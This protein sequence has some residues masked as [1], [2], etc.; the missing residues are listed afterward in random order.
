MS[1]DTIPDRLLAQAAAR[2]DAPA[3]WHQPADSGWQAISWRQYA[4]LAEAFAGALLAMDY[5]PGW[6]VAI[7]SDNC[8][9]WLV[10]DLGA[11]LARAVPA[12]VYPT[13]TAEQAAY[14]ISHCEA[15]VVV[16]QDP[17]QWA[18]LQ[19]VLDQ[20]PALKRVVIIHGADAVDD[21]LAVG[22]EA[23]LD[24]GRAHGEAVQ[25][26]VA[27]LVPEDLGTLIYTS[28]TTGHPK[29]VMLDHRNLAFTA[30]SALSAVGEV[31]PE[32]CM[33]SYLPLSHIAEQ[34]FS[35][36]LHTTAGYPLWLCPRLE[37]LKATLLV[38]RPTFFL[39][40][41]RVWEKFKAA[42][43]GK[44]GELTGVKGAIA[45][46]ALAVGLRA[47]PDLVAHGEASGALGWQ[48]RLADRLFYGKLKAQLGLDRLK[49]ASSG[50]APIGRDVVQ[51][52]WAIGVPIHEVYGQSEGTGP[53]T[54]NRP[55]PGERRLGTVGLPLPGVEV[56]IAEDGEILVRGD[57][58]FVGY[59]K[60][61]AD[62]AEALQDGW[63]HSGDVGRF[64]ADGF[65]C[66]TDRKKDL[67]ITAGGKNVAPQHIEALLKGIAGVGQAVVIGDRRKYLSA[68]LTVDPEAT[69]ALAAQHGWPT[70]PQALAAH[71]G[72]KA[73]VDAGVAAVNGQLARYETLKRW[74]VL[75]DDFTLEG[76]ELTPTQKV[77]RRV[78]DAKYA[79]QIEALYA[80]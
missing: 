50:A 35:V 72:F 20:L 18:K 80:P 54:F 59:L 19:S 38:A 67:I 77:K 29:G 64:D 63:L 14:I 75:P 51:F 52:F 62:T 57:N 73:H 49:V 1:R 26:R 4:E 66:I 17:L 65:L 32:D 46:W 39:G 55:V 5:A 16:V 21:P 78:V 79:A 69:P 28:G 12:G 40:V 13:L 24:E 30:R 22:F 42:L 61:P 2:P 10:A 36:H 56:R 58:V 27:E 60:Q 47:V 15:R 48:H 44:L 9:P 25:A 43:E 11:M 76:G 71:A 33:I 70:D 3:L 74:T 68:L 41:P 45:R 7:L 53:T 23:F 31:G 8:V 6:G 37:D 34:M